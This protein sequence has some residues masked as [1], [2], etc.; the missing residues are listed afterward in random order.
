MRLLFFSFM[1]SVT[2]LL[3]FSGCAPRAEIKVFPNGNASMK[4]KI[5]PGKT[6][7]EVLVRFAQM[8]DTQE[9]KDS[10]FDIPDIKENLVKQGFTVR[11]LEKKSFAGLEADIGARWNQSLIKSV[12]NTKKGT[13]D[14]H[15]APEDLKEIHALLPDES[16]EYADLLMA[17]VFT[18]EELSVDEYKAV[19][20]SA[21]GEKIAK[22]LTQSS[23]DF[24]I[25]CP[26]KVQ[27]ASIEPVG[28]V[29]YQKNADTVKAVVPL[30]DILTLKEKVNVHIEYKPSSN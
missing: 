29:T 23:F 18:G 24:T 21:Y 19:V 2:I 4:I 26:G 3:V 16:K 7:E 9:N 10:I 6:T 5:I 1:V 28:K 12:L 25:R 14:F 11:A 30:V 8:S 15:L 20:F 13:I 22:E 27:T 17:P